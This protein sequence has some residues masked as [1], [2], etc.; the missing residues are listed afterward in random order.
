MATTPKKKTLAPPSEGA[1]H[2]IPARTA[3]DELRANVLKYSTQI[4]DQYIAGQSFV[5]IAES[6]P[7]KIPGWRL[8]TLLQTFEETKDSYWTLNLE[9]AH[10]LIEAAI[11]NARA[12]ALTGDPAGYR[13]ANDTYLKVAAKI[14]PAEYGDKSKLEL[15]GKDGGAIQVKAD[16][17]L[18]PADAYERL[19]GKS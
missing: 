9:R 18:S 15:T 7:F 11:D 17:T 6:L 1:L 13:V 4:M 2:R 12:A 19:I 8:R 10:N 14:A 5:Q 3:A 16:M